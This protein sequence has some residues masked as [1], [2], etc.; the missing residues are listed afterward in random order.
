MKIKLKKEYELSSTPTQN[1]HAMSVKTP[2]AFN[3]K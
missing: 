2:S 3:H 1:A